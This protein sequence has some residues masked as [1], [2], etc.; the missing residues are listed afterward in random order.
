MNRNDYG[1]RKLHS[2][3]Q[4]DGPIYRSYRPGLY[5]V[6]WEDYPALS[7][8][9]EKVER[10]T[11]S[12]RRALASEELVGAAAKFEFEARRPAQQFLRQQASALLA[13][14]C[15]NYAE[16]YLLRAIADALDRAKGEAT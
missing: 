13:I 4:F 8:G 16:A 2:Q 10:D 15:F 12:E 1:P 5:R 9:A 6:F 11:D 7:A 14:G 3:N